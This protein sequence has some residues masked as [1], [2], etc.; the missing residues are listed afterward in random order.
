ERTRDLGG[1]NIPAGS[2]VMIESLTA[3]TANEMFTADGVKGSGHVVGKVLADL[4][5]IMERANDVVIVADDIFSDG[6][7]YDSLTESYVKALAEL[8]V[9]IAGVADEVIEVI[10]GLQVSYKR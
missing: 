4:S 2:S 9:R 3:W 1:V 6:G 10:S 8:T 7:E 5:V